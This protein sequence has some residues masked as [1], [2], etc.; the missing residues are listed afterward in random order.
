MFGEGCDRHGIEH[1]LTKPKHPWT[2]GQVERMN[3]AVKEATVNRYS[4]TAH[5]Q[6]KTPRHS[7]LRA[8]NFARR[9]KTRKGLTPY[10]D[11]GKIWTQEPA[12][13]VVNP[14][15]HTVGLTT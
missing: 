4:S 10:E 5:D 8:Y 2:N 14:F 1:W 3:R 6:L 7:F 11:I 13:F 12:R 15:Q 9:L